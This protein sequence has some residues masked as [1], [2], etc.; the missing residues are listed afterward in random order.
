MTVQPQGRHALQMASAEAS[1]DRNMYLNEG[2]NGIA[3]STGNPFLRGGYNVHSQDN[4]ILMQL[5][6]ADEEEERQFRRHMDWE[7][8]FVHEG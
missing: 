5:A 2:T 1:E 6:A 8:G 4:D 7:D 3:W